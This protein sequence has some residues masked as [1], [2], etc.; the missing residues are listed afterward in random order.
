MAGAP[1][2]EEGL[3]LDDIEVLA[4]GYRRGRVALGAVAGAGADRAGQGTVAGEQ[5]IGP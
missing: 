1:V 5:L 4:A 2:Q 3:M